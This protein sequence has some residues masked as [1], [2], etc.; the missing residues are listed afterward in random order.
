MDLPVAIQF[1]V[2]NTRKVRTR[3]SV[4][5]VAEEDTFERE[6]FYVI[7][8]DILDFR[9]GYCVAKCV[10]PGDDFFIG[11]Y[12]EK[13]TEDDSKVFFKL[14]NVTAKFHSETVISTVLSLSQETNGTYAMDKT[15]VND[16]IFSVNNIM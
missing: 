2:S 7:R 16:I 5:T 15:E 9:D 4:D 10:K 6:K 8:A 12:L 3:L 13:S 11:S 1:R 14:S